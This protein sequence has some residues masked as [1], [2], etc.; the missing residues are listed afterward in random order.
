MQE[1]LKPRTIFGR[2]NLEVLRGLN[3][4]SVDLIYLDPPFN[5]K[6]VFTA[7][8]ESASE[9]ASFDDIFRKAH[10]K[11]E[12][13]GLI[14][15]KNPTLYA[16]IQGITEIGHKSNK[17]YL[18]YMAVRLMELQRVLKSTGSLYLHCDTTMSHYLKL[19]LDCIFGEDN[20]RNE[21]IWHYKGTGNQ[22]TKFPAKHDAILYYS[23]S[24][25]AHHNIIYV[26]A[27][28]ESGWTG[29]D[30]KKCDSVWTDIGTVFQSQERAQ[31]TG[32]PLSFLALT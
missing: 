30:Q 31:A 5:K 23:A 8:I 1:T 18:C 22:K 24:S 27:K 2:D 21:I 10:V 19:L 29:K 7:P 3:D 11:E 15:D 6:K 12:W 13:L 20:F 28:K 26:K 32:Y 25:K 4:R 9:G 17:Y 16:Y 14:A